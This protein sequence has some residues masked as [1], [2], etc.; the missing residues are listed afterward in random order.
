MLAG[1][2]ILR[3]ILKKKKKKK[4]KERKEKLLLHSLEPISQT[5][6]I[7]TVSSRLSDFKTSIN[8]RAIN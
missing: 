2:V 3:L 1:S 7:T 5:F 4:K 8:E 6:P